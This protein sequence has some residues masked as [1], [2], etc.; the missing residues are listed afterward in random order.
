[1]RRKVEP[2]GQQPATQQAPTQ[3]QQAPAQF[4]DWPATLQCPMCKAV[5][6]A[7]KCQHIDKTSRRCVKCGHALVSYN[8]FGGRPEFVE[9]LPTGELVPPPEDKPKPP[10]EAIVD[11]EK[12]MGAG[13]FGRGETPKF[14]AGKAVEEMTKGLDEVFANVAKKDGVALQESMPDVPTIVGNE[15]TCVS[16]EEAYGKTGS[17]SSYRVG[18]IT[19]RETLAAGADRVAAMKKALDD[20]R[21]VKAYEREKQHEAFVANF[22]KV[23]AS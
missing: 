14:D 4:S 23:Q 9:E 22:R 19:I 3:A 21:E 5:Q 18:S 11:R 8:A 10:L 2:A 16:G 13:F 15:I 1:M 7:A 6:I 17:F 20:M 12:A